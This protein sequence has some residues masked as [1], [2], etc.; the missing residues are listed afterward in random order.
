M[1][2]WSLVRYLRTACLVVVCLA[3][4]LPELATA[5]AY[6]SQRSM[7][8]QPHPAVARIVVK[9]G[10]GFAF[11]SGSLID[12]RGEYGLVI[13]NWHVVR[14]A[15]GSIEVV[16]PSGFRSE[17]RSIKLD[18]DWDLAA[19]VIWKPPVEPIAL[20]TRAPRPGE[21]LTICGYGAGQYRAVSGRCTDYYAPQIGMPHELVELDVEARQGDSGGPI[22][23]AQG[24]IAGVLFGAG[25]GTTLGSF[26]GRVGTF[27]ASLGPTTEP[28]TSGPSLSPDNESKMVAVVSPTTETSPGHSSDVGFSQVSTSQFAESESPSTPWPSNTAI[29]TH[30]LAKTSTSASVDGPSDEPYA[31]WNCSDIAATN[32]VVAEDANAGPAVASL[33]RPPALTAGATHWD[34]GGGPPE[35]FESLKSIF[36]V[37]GIVFIM[38][39][40]VRVAT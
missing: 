33:P 9:E 23:N 28:P 34:A 14:E 18:E 3:A 11:G 21:P 26:G 5:S 30:T 19:L 12:T 24:E 40:M 4:T 10:S 35:W 16:F 39:W 38:L 25:Q 17:A 36:A 22:L 31:P 20:S 1:N 13:T 2:S 27:L 6:S 32:I 37:I 8:Q 15:T 29:N 7:P